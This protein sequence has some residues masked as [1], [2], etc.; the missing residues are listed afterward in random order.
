MLTGNFITRKIQI[1]GRYLFVVSVIIFLIFFVFSAEA[2]FKYFISKNW[3][4]FV[5]EKETEFENEVRFKFD[6]YQGTL[7]DNLEIVKKNIDSLN[8]NNLLN[9]ASLFD[10]LNLLKDDGIA[11]IL[12]DS[13]GK[14]I[15]WKNPFTHIIDINQIKLNQFFVTKSNI[16]KVLNLSSQIQ[17]NGGSIIYIVVSRLLDQNYKISS[18]FI[19][20][21]L[22]QKFFTQE[23]KRSIFLN[24]DDTFNEDK[25]KTIQLLGLD[26]SPLI[27]VSYFPLTIDDIYYELENY[28]SL[29]KI[30]LLLILGSFLLV[31]FY[32][33]TN[34]IFLTPVKEI[35]MIVELW[36]FRYFLVC[37]GFPSDI[38]DVSIFNPS[39][40]ASNFGYGLAKSI[41]ELLI[42]SVTLFVSLHFLSPVFNFIINHNLI[43]QKSWIYK[44]LIAIFS[45]LIVLILLRGYIATLNSTIQDSSL[46]YLQQNEVFPAFEKLVMFVALIL[47]SFSFVLI[48][49]NLAKLSQ[50]VI[51]DK[52]KKYLGYIK[53]LILALLASLIF[54]F[55][56]NPLFNYLQG[57][58]ILLSF[59][60][61]SLIIK[62]FHDIV[63]RKRD[64][65]L[66]ILFSSV[67]LVI[68]FYSELEKDRE[69]KLIDLANQTIQPFDDWMAFIV[70]EALNE[71]ISIDIERNVAS[72]NRQELAFNLWANS[73]LSQKGYDCMVRIIDTNLQIISKFGIGSV[74]TETQSLNF[75]PDKKKVKVNELKYER[76]EV[77]YYS[78]YAPLF[79]K[80]NK[81]I[82]AII[83]D[84][85]ASRN[86]LLDQDKTS[87]F[88]VG[89]YAEDYF[90]NKTYYTEYE[91]NRISFSTNTEF[92]KSIKI[93][94]NI[95]SKLNESSKRFYCIDEV[96]NNKQYKSVY[97]PAGVKD[98]II[99]VSVE[100][101]GWKKFE[102]LRLFIYFIF[103]SLL[104]AFLLSLKKLKDIFKFTI[105]TKL[106]IIFILVSIIPL[107]IL[108]Y[109]NNIYTEE[110][111]NSEMISNLER[112]IEIILNQLTDYVSKENISERVLLTDEICEDIS[113]KTGVDFI[114]Y[115]NALY[116]GSS[117]SEF[118]Q[119]E[120]ISNIIS[121]EA[122]KKIMIEGRQFF[123][124]AHKIG[125]FSYYVGY[126]PVLIYSKNISGIVSVLTL[127]K[128]AQLEAELADRNMYMFGIYFLVLVFVIVISSI[129]SS[130]IS[131]PLKNLLSYTKMVGNGNLEVRINSRRTDEMGE[132]ENAF[133]KMTADL[134]QK[135]DELIKYEKEI[136]WKEMAKQV[137][138]EIKNPLTPIKLSIQQMYRAYKDGAK[139]FDEIF[140]Q[141]YDLITEQIETLSRIASEFSS[142]AR[143]PERKLELCFVQEVLDETIQLFVQYP[144]IKINKSYDAE[145]LFVIADRD[146]LRRAFVNI[147]RN[148]VQAMEYS[149]VVEI[150]ASKKENKIQVDIVDYGPG[151]SDEIAKRI[152]EP[153]F[154]TKSDGMGLGLAIVKRTIEDM[155][156]E[157]TFETKVG[158]GTKFTIKLNAASSSN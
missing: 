120:L 157:I 124:E 52:A 3:E 92:P 95:F 134:K 139:N 131:K 93:S 23:F 143:M 137:A 10:A 29:I 78:G 25:F 90:F 96:I 53:L 126:K 61:L 155:N 19:Q 17:I 15:S 39:Y 43:K 14:L 42:T 54:R 76:G 152:F 27:N 13:T 107:F 136:A 119:A 65:L 106:L 87:I 2:L 5:V 102:V 91:D 36:I 115:S 41:A 16:Y 156:G 86:E 145:K 98:K 133:D 138:H 74:V 109:Y 22:N 45:L 99:S 1:Q 77:R 89:R 67:I 151:I 123:A 68:L 130:Q 8:N 82:G 72:G 73:L 108:G 153:N 117:L 81:I 32:S 154:S 66:L 140:K 47:L 18:R 69:Q 6:W 125:G 127:S 94:E 7:R 31:I 116:M 122:Y 64:S 20:Q 112:E 148:S 57:V 147:I 37:I 21:N 75:I 62:S 100:I 158:Y 46:N 30:L 4:K 60:G 28:F 83:L 104:L 48:G 132:L 79:D 85:T 55:H 26:K 40:F 70:D 49:L 56:P 58:L 12:Y 9:Q 144:D 113:K 35:V 121:A 149:G 71:M 135:R 51:I 118:I 141:A 59:I 24:I 88:V 38:T 84:V 44:Y 80:S 97:I 103:I 105:F 129:F 34:K 33:I 128:I 11:I 111:M 63:S 146:E 101:P 114:F 50:K 142:F 150:F 110:R